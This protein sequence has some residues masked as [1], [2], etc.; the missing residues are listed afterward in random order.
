MLEDRTVLTSLLF[1]MATGQL[2]IAAPASD[3]SVSEA[4]TAAGFVDITLDG[5]SHSSDPASAAFDP[6]LAGASRS[7]LTDIAFDGGAADTLV[8][9]SQAVDGGLQVSAPKATV[10]TEDVSVAGFLAVKASTIDIR[11]ALDA[12]SVALTA[13]DWTTVEAKGTVTASTEAS[14]GNIAVESAVFVNSGQLHADGLI[15][16]QIFVSAG[17]VL[18]GGSI[19]ADG[20]GQ[21]GSVRV[22]FTDSYIDTS[23][24]V[25]SADGGKG[26]P[27]ALAPGGFVTIDGGVT[28]HLFS[29]GT[30]QATGSSGGQVD[31][32]GREIELVGASVDASGEAGGG[33]IRI[34]GDFHSNVGQVANLPAFGGQA[35]NAPLTNA[36]TVTVTAATSLRADARSDGPGGRVVVWTDEDTTFDGSVSARG[37][38]ASGN[39]G[40]IEISGLGNLDYA[41]TADTSAPAGK[42][43]TL[44]LDPKNLIIDAAAGV[45]PQFDFVD[46]RPAAGAQFGSSVTVLNNGNVVV[47]NPKDDFGGAGAGAVYLYDGLTGAL[48][49]ALVGNSAGANVGGHIYLVGNGNYVIQSLQWN[50]NLGAVTW[51][52]GTVGLTGAV[53]ADNSLVGSN[54]NDSVGSLGILVLSNGNYLVQSPKWNGTFGAV[55]WGSGTAGV[56]G[57]V[58]AA[59]SLIGGDE[60]DYVGGVGDYPPTQIS[61]VTVLSNGNYVVESPHWNANRGA[62]T[63]GSGTAGVSGAISAINSLIG[64]N[65]ADVVGYLTEVFDTS[66]V[67]ALSNG[68][69][70]VAS[71]NWNGNLGAATW[72]SGTAGVTGIISAS[73]SLVGSSAGDSVGVY[74]ITPLTNGNYVVASPFWNGYRGAATWASGTAGVTGA[75]SEANSLVGSSPYDRVGDSTAFIN[76]TPGVVALSNGNYLVRSPFWKSNGDYL[77][78]FGAVTWGNG[79]VG[80]TGIVS[81]SNSLVGSNSGDRVGFVDG[82]SSRGLTVLTNDN[83]VVYSPNWNG[84]RGAVTWDSD[85]AGVTGVVSAANSLVGSD[86]NDA[87]GYDITALSDGNY[88]VDSSNWNGNRGAATWGSGTAGITGVI[89]AANSLVGSNPNDRVGIDI[90]P[91]SNGNY[92]VNDFDWNGNRGA[93]TWGSGTAGVTGAVSAANSLVGSNPNDDVGDFGVRPLS[94][95]NYVVI[96]NEWNAGRGAVTWGSG[97]AGV[98]GE[99]SASNSLIG[100]NPNDRVGGYISLLSNGNYVVLS[101]SWNGSRGAATWGSGTVGVTGVVSAANSLVGSNPNDHVGQYVVVQLSNGNYVEPSPNWNG[102]RGAVTWGSGM[103]GISGEISAANSLVGTNPGDDVG[104]D[105]TYVLSNADYVVGSPYP[106]STFGAETWVSG[107]SGQTLDGAAIITPQNSVLVLTPFGVVSPPVDDPLH[108]AF[109]AA[110]S[111]GT[112][113]VVSAFVDPNQLTFARGQAQTITITPDFLTRTLNSGGAVILQASNDITINSPITVS[114]GG[115]GGALTLQAGRSIVIN[116]SITTDNG[117]L[118][119][120]ANDT[121]ASGVADAQRDPGNAVITMADGTVLDTGAAPLAIELRDGAGKTNTSSGPISLQTINAHT[122]SVLNNGPSAGSD[123][124]LGAVTTT[125][126]QTY[127]KPHGVTLVTAD[128]DSGGDPITFN[129][130]VV[131]GAGVS[132]GKSDSNVIFDGSGTQTLQPGV[133]AV[134][135]DLHHTGAGTLQLLGDLIV[136]GPL[137][138]AA[139]IFDANDNAV[140]VGEIAVITGGAYKAGTA[141]QTFAS[142]LAILGGAFKRSSGPMTI[143]GTVILLGGEFDGD[144]TVDNLAD[145]HGT[146]APGVGVLNATGAVTLLSATFRVNL[147]GTEPGTDYTQMQAAGPIDLGGSQLE[148]DLGF[149]PSVGSTF[150]ILT[151]TD[152][153]GIIGTFAG[154]DEGATFSQDEF[155]FQITYHGGPSGTSVVLTRVS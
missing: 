84:N 45:F 27:G 136:V 41:G 21:G 39:G 23:A 86:P 17:K 35:S 6:L 90:L 69:Y 146:L 103:T 82:N 29:S 75:V 107:T 8:L 144:G 16:G 128:L 34:G 143:S 44:L 30:F 74:G 115:H 120:I 126:T 81:A 76:L 127:R 88:V 94:N 138:Q 105:G 129:D 2:A 96:S 122:L 33:S 154:L 70:V 47:Q 137:V 117:P 5:Q 142:A 89:S 56:S 97:T 101:Q 26:E 153:G 125:G 99:V 114:A 52:S 54:S 133:G 108:Q 78:A 64:T 13:S 123:I 100:G 66:G 20:S 22:A 151:T 95:G 112:G 36:Q 77:N 25:T 113:R 85:T 110:S 50:G 67:T 24:A 145:F 58:S 71:P 80:I 152:P 14:G 141:T 68:N 131:V 57:E 60:G 53:S 61:G 139:G 87:V 130:S 119:L 148:L 109:L 7:T 38:P 15:G 1:D 51:C 37:G 118:T 73:N 9:D 28:G 65:P 48:L 104:L 11:G 19:S 32:F 135:S 124:Y 83:Y 43:G 10:A 150:T 62:A 140:S 4:L 31:L 3:H 46:P 147:N 63:W 79:T 116:A 40:F 149:A 121:L 72:G 92:V 132:V 55:T 155:T 91:L 59:N 18:N 98:T 49:S 12:A 111:D 93:A 102:N 42:A 106:D 134:F